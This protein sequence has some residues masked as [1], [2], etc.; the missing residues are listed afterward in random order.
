[1]DRTGQ[2]GVE[3]S[4]CAKFVLGV[5]DPKY[6]IFSFNS[7]GGVMRDVLN[8]FVKAYFECD[9]DENFDRPPH[10]SRMIKSTLELVLSLFLH[11][12]GFHNTIWPKMQFHLNFSLFRG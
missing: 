7:T 9:K 12:F 10:W 11:S 1:M 8:Q 4:C 3:T 2:D 6:C 5:R